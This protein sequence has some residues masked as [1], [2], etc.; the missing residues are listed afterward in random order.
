MPK[1]VLIVDDDYAVQQLYIAWFELLG[2]ATRAAYN[3][4]LALE[5]LSKEKID[6]IILDLA[7]PTAEGEVVLEKMLATPALTQIPVI[8][9]SALGP[10][11]GRPAR[12][13]ERYK[14][15]LRYAF[16]RRPTSL[17][18]IQETIEKLGFL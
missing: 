17:E 2:C 13:D 6:L 15:K 7:M 12:I 14:G 5:V 18:K 11:T 10:E 1:T 16:F 8:I 4:A 9:D 3:G